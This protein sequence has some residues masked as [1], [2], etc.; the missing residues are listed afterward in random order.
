MDGLV[1]S[2]SNHS[3]KMFPCD[4]FLA[5]WFVFL[6]F[7]RILRVQWREKPHRFRA[8]LVFLVSLSLSLSLSLPPPPKQKR[9]PCLF[10]C[11]SFVSKDLKGSSVEKN[12]TL[13]IFGISLFFSP[14]RQG[15]EGVE[16]V[17]PTQ[18]G[19]SWQDSSSNT[20]RSKSN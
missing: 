15:L 6:L 10:L 9:F 1:H 19:L 14:K 13:L 16:V 11:F 12:K 3:F 17:K 8:I 20:G 5:F 4:N 2:P 7:P 18:I